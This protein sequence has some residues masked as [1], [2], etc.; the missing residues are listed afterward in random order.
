MPAPARAHQ[1]VARAHGVSVSVR[2]A[3]RAGA[4]LR[5]RSA[6]EVEGCTRPLPSGFQQLVNM[7]ADMTRQARRLIDVALERIRVG[8]LV[9]VEN[10]D[11]RVYGHGGAPAATVYV[12]SPRLWPML[13]RGSRGL[14]EAYAN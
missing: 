1:C 3:A 5:P 9:V 12:R 6:A 10:G 14:A 4:D 8:S 11:S 2:G 7:Q 13:L